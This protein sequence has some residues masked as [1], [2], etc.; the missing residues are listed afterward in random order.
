[1]Q[2]PTPSRAHIGARSARSSPSPPSSPARPG[3]PWHR[4]GIRPSRDRRPTPQAAPMHPIPH[5]TAGH[6]DDERQPRPTMRTGGREWPTLLAALTLPAVGGPAA[7]A[8]YRHARDVITEHGDPVM[9][10]W[11]ALTTDGMLLAALVVIWV[12]RHRRDPVGL[13]PWAAFWAGMTATIAANFAAAPAHDSSSNGHHGPVRTGRAP[14]SDILAWLREQT[15]QPGKCPGAGNDRQMGPRVTPRRPPTPHRPRRSRTQHRH[16]LR[17]STAPV[18]TLTSSVQIP[19]G[20]A[21]TTLRISLAIPPPP[22]V[23]GCP[24]RSRP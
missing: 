2:D 14:D 21:V 10:P 18:M 7:V 1:V 23:A 12:R 4:R 6:V 9:A 13:G 3:N 5:R 19:P 8:S 11:L 16:R 15:A 22:L 17:S 20:G 24:R